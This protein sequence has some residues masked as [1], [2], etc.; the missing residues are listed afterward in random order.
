MNTQTLI[1]HAD[2][3]AA[4]YP[5][6]VSLWTFAEAAGSARIACGPHR[7]ALREGAGPVARVDD[8]VFGPHAAEFRHGN[9]LSIPRQ[10][11]PALALTRQ[12]TLVAWVKRHRKPEV[13]CEAIAGLWD[14]TRAQRQYA[15]FLDLRIHQSGDNAAGHVSHH[16]GP[17]PGYPWCMDAA[18]GLGYVDYFAWHCVAMSYDGQMVRTYLDGRLDSRPG[19]NPFAYPGSLHDAGPAGADFTVGA[20]HRGGEMGNWFVGRLGGLA[21]YDRALS[22]TQQAALAALTPGPVRPPLTCPPTLP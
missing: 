12:L 5:G 7:Y 13:Q 18:I 4:E 1:T 10:E 3:L 11:C 16:G 2:P 8:G 9:Y 19:F 14:E 17:T 15:L 20:V 6:L 22:D 21:V